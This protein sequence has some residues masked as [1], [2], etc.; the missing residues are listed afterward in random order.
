M[1]K[2]IFVLAI[3]SLMGCTTLRYEDEL[4]QPYSQAEI[5]L[6]GVAAITF[7]VASTLIA[8]YIIEQQR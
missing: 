2:I 6:S 3:V 1:K 5:E 4:V 7:G 8:G